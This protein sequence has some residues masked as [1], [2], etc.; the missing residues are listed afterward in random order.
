MKS[1][2]SRDPAALLERWAILLTGSPSEAE[3]AIPNRPEPDGQSVYV[4]DVSRLNDGNALVDVICADFA[5]PYRIVGLDALLSVLSDLDWASNPA[6]YLWTIKGLP[7]LLASNEALF[8]AFVGLLPHLCDRWRSRSVLFR[9]LVPVN[10]ATMAEIKDVIGREFRALRA[11]PAE[12]RVDFVEPVVLEN[13]DGGWR[14]AARSRAP[15]RT[16]AR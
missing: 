9:V 4:S 15:G 2:S 1:R 10:R 13:V 14:V 7:S 11:A 12:W 16:L 3:K 8:R 6:G 5:V